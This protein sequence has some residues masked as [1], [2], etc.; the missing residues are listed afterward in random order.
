MSR[1]VLV[2]VVL[3]AA[4]C[5]GS[6]VA[7]SDSQ[8]AATAQLGKVIET[9]C[10]SV[11]GGFRS[12]T[13]FHRT[14]GEVSR[15][16]HRDGS[17]WSVLL[18]ADR[19]PYPLHGWWRRVLADPRREMLL[20]E[21]SGE[22]EVPF[23]YLITT[24]TTVLHQVFTAQPVTPLGWT[25]DGLARVKLW[26]PIRASKTR[27]ARPS[28]IYLVTPKGQVVRQERRVPASPGC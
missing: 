7:Q 15:I 5:G 14:G 24:D 6:N 27:I 16:E 25:N 1:L 17:R 23:T 20:A 26:K 18:A 4:G 3:L 2:A 28:G 19:A 22:C 12:C 13:V 21:W 8:T 11:S 10:S 9:R